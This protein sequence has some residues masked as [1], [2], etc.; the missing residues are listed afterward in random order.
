MQGRR[1]AGVAAFALTAATVSAVLAS[2]GSSPTSHRA[3]ASVRQSGL[4]RAFSVLSR[5]AD[6]AREQNAFKSAAGRL[7]HVDAA[8]ASPLGLQDKN[9]WA[10]ANSLSDLC[11][12]SMSGNEVSGGCGHAAEVEG[13]GLFTQSHPAPADIRAQ[14]LAAGTVDVVALLPDGVQSVEFTFADGTRR[15]IEVTDNGMAARFDVQPQRARFTD[16][17]GNPHVV[18]VG[19]Q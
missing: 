11:V 9:V 19:A 4:E 15:D 12:A 1:T 14:D 7:M 5:T 8:G 18:D 16:A 10:A 13:D 2:T 17:D 6:Q 3:T